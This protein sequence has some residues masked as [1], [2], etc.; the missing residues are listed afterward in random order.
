MRW[1]H[2]KL[3][4]HVGSYAYTGG[5]EAFRRTRTD[6]VANTGYIGYIVDYQR[7]TA[8]TNR[9]QTGYNTK[10]AKDW[11]AS[12]AHAQAGEIETLLASVPGGGAENDGCSK[13]KTKIIQTALI[14]G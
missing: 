10:V 14:V 1:L 6:G 2:V 13:N 11:G 8:V 7:L 3:E 5:G 9:V 4:A 12:P